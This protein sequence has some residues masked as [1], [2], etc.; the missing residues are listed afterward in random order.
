MSTGGMAAPVPADRRVR[1]ALVGC[2]RIAANHVA[3]IQRAG[4]RAS[5]PGR[6][7][8]AFLFTV[9]ASLLHWAIPT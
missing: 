8:R 5:P 1:F 6:S 2:G 4:M 7:A 9:S 3:A